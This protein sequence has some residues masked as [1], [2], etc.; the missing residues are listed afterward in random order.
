MKSKLITIA[1]LLLAISSCKKRDEHLPTNQMHGAEVK[2]GGGFVRSIVQTND[3]NGISAL[4]ISIDKDALEHLPQGDQ[5]GGH[6]HAY[7]YLLPLPAHPSLRP[8]DHVVLNWNPDGHPPVAIY[9]KPHFDFHFY[10]ISQAER[11]AIP[12]YA[13]DSNSFK[14]Y[15]MPAYLPANYAPTPG[16]EAKMGTHWIDVTSPELAPTGAAPFTQTIIYGTFG[17]KVNFLEPMISLDF[18][19][20]RKSFTR[21]IP[22]PQQ[23]SKD[24]SYPTQM[25]IVDLGST[26]EVRLHGFVYHRKS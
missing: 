13:A 2:L 24:G 20:Q 3:T 5:H 16:G 25:S 4:A 7:S 17:G 18:L 22:Q 10:T 19:K 9:D 14:A 1:I 8:F 11:D 26:I 6:E 23:F 21:L 12:P 15:P